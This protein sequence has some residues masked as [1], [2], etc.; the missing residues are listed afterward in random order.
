VRAA[1]AAAAQ[2]AAAEAALAATDAA[3]SESDATAED[4]ARRQEEFGQHIAGVTARIEQRRRITEQLADARTH[5]N[6][7]TLR[8]KIPFDRACSRATRICWDA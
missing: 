8:V 7:A 4:A 5:R 1:A 6:V 3:L 2:L